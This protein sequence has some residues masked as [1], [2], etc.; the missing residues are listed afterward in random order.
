MNMFSHMYGYMYSMFKFQNKQ[1]TVKILVTIKYYTQFVQCIL[2]TDKKE[3]KIFLIYREIQ[4]GAGKVIYEE[5]LPNIWG[6]RKY[7]PIYEEAVI[8]VKYGL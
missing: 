4:S 7:F 8:L 5:R 6:K 3:N 2:L 1:H